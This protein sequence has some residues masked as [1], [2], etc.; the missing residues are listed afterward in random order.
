MKRIYDNVVFDHIVNYNKMIFLAGPRQVGKTT[1]AKKAKSLADEVIYLNWD[2]YNDQQLILSGPNAIAEQF[3]LQQLRDISTLIIF[4]EI[5]KYERWKNFLKGFFDSYC[6]ATKII[7]TGSAK[8]DIY[9]TSGD[10][11]MGRYFPYRVHP[12]SVAECIRTALP[13]T[14]IQSPK[15]INDHDFQTLLDFG[16]F[17]EVFIARNK[18]FYNRWQNLWQQ[19]LFREDLRDLRR[20]LEMAQIEKLAN[21][22]KYQTGQLVNYSNLANKVN[23]SSHT[24]ENW[25]AILSAFY[26]CYMIKP[27]TK[28]ISRSLIKQPKIYLWDWSKIEDIGAKIENFVASHLL[29]AV[30]FWTDS[31]FGNY[32]LF[33]LRDKDKREVDFLVTKDEKPWF[34]VE[35]KNSHNVPLSKNLEVFQKQTGAEYAF[36]VTL[37]MDYVNKDCF[38]HKQPIIVPAQTFLSQLI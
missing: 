34:L 10:S 24:I 23:V 4:D 12:L 36:Q 21:L 17:P 19:H 11:M 16:G 1:I 22:L 9:R 8:L 29:K 13:T 37:N 31:G 14:E 2:N 35:V 38:L 27:W 6:D 28:N 26:Y 3:N 25:L 7:V 33:F 30:H 18:R 15:K 5:H 32:D 20:V